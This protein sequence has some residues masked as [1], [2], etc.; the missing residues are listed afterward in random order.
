MSRWMIWPLSCTLMQQTPRCGVWEC[1]NDESIN[2]LGTFVLAVGTFTVT[3]LSAY[4]G[5]RVLDPKGSADP[6][7]KEEED[8]GLPTRSQGCMGAAEEEMVARRLV[9]VKAKF[10]VE[11]DRKLYTA[12]LGA[13]PMDVTCAPV[14]VCRACKN[15]GWS[16]KHHWFHECPGF[17]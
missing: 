12:K 6:R 13:E 3:Y 7:E 17:E 10:R 2:R 11:G 9:A 14:T 5:Q 1:M 16:V 8:P 4:R 15:A